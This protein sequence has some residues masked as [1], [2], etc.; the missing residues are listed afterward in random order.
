LSRLRDVDDTA[1]FLGGVPP[2][3]DFPPELLAT[4][5]ARTRVVRLEAGDWLFRQH[6]EGGSLYVVRSGRLELVREDPAPPSAVGVL[7][8]GDALGELSLLLQEPRTLS[9]RAIRDSEVLCLDREDA[10][11][12]LNDSAEFSA[13]LTRV[14]ARYLQDRALARGLADAQGSVLTI[15]AL[16]P[17]ASIERLQ[18]AMAAI[19][20][21]RRVAV[22][23]GAGIDGADFSAVLDRAERENDRVFLLAGGAGAPPG[24]DD[25]CLRQADRLI[26]L[27]PPGLEAPRLGARPELV[28]CDI[29]F[30]A[31]PGTMPGVQVCLDRLSPRSHHYVDPDDLKPTVARALRRLAGLSVGVVLSGGGALAMAHIGV[32]AE[33][34]EAGVV[35]DRIGGASFGALVGGLFA[36]GLSADEVVKQCRRELVSNWPFNDYAVPRVAL[37]RGRKLGAALDR[38]F[39]GARIE[40]AP[41]A[42]FAVSADLLTSE[43]AVHRRGRFADALQAALAL[44]GMLPPVVDDG[45]LLIDGSAL[46]GLPVA[47]MAAAD[48]GPVIAV[49]VTVAPLKVRRSRM[50]GGLPNI[51]E[52]ISRSALIGGAV[53]AAASR[54]MARL[55]VQP[56]AGTVG[57][58]EFA[59]LDELVAAGREAARNAL[60][61]SDDL[62][63]T[64]VPVS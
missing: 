3:N 53:D 40:E 18:E 43:V 10:L 55:V 58:F 57:Q 9:V 33:L 2:F 16:H 64:V 30:W 7:G 29:V 37:L 25:F 47:E 51:T 23:D 35:V 63:T 17:D 42:Y 36:L 20:A 26:A 45:R 50:L 61:G 8:P 4:V 48:E 52:T 54:G 31:R 59:R 27:V 21:K 38:M 13:G 28:G 44:P 12:L 60:A 39:G 49:D 19:P 1:G 11:G 62:F 34:A 41:L 5:A 32:L 6:D 22:I 56:E 15:L 46:R 24:W 14:L